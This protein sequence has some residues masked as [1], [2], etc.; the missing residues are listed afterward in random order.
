MT[1]TNP[2][3]GAI[4]H[5]DV[6]VV[7]AGFSGISMLYRLRKAGLNAKVF[8]SGGDFGGVWYWNRYPGARVDSEWPYYQLNIPEVYRDWEFSEKF[9]GHKEIRAYC[10]H[11]DKVLN[12]RKDVQFNAHVV[13]ARWSKSDETWTVKTEQGHIAQSK[14]LI[15]CTGLLHRRH[16]PDFPGLTT[17]KGT[18]HHTGFWP[19]DMSVKG[20]KVGIIG[21]GATAVQVVQEL[22]KE[23]DQL[24]VFMRRPSLCLPMGQ[25]PISP[26]EQRGWKS[27]FQALFREGRQS[28]A[29]FPGTT[30]PCGVFDV[31]DEERERHF[32]D[33]WQRGGFNYLMVNYNDVVL[34]KESN[35]KV[36]N[37]WAK[38]IRQRIKD[39]RK[40]ELMVPVEAPY[41]FGTKRCPLEQ[42]YYEMLDR[43]NV[44]IVNMNQNPLKTFNAT[45]MLMEDGTQLDF[46]VVVLATGFDSFSGSLT[47]MGLKNKD[48]VDIKD[49]WKDGIRTYLGMT[50]NGFPNV[51][52][53]YTPHAPTAL[54]NG[55]TIIEAQS[56]FIVSAIQ[57]LEKEGASTIEP[58]PDAED[59]WDAMIDAMNKHTLF[60]LTNS[61]WNGANIPGKKVQILTHPGGIQMYEGQ[62][63]ATL[64]D[65]KGFTVVHKEG[66][67]NGVVTAEKGAATEKSVEIVAPV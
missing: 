6:L 31:S 19:E 33:I 7:G 50:F 13:D 51:F 2:S 64:G 27:Y 30:E 60:P 38:K 32:E 25:R 62:C 41:Y 1:D 53:V 45:G 29:G 65:W 46:D 39:P 15:L 56:D 57:K 43:P 54:S 47:Q 26:E 44:D 35:Q 55:P 61:W 17:Y 5:C 40:Q 59:E 20:K 42:D 28:R 12:L 52:M 14:Y 8:E 4:V 63:R 21:A 49:V 36:Y 37:F 66:G 3:M 9:P 11:V 24:T 16:I 22:A 67:S 10:A 58:N 34:S 48:G 18:L 23:A